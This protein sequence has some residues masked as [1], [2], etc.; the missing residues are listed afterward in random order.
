MTERV[1][2][3]DALQGWLSTDDVKQK[4]ASTLRGYERVVRKMGSL[5]KAG[6]LPVYANDLSCSDLDLVIDTL[7]AGSSNGRQRKLKPRSEA[8]L[9]TDRT[10]LRKICGYFQRQ[11][12]T[13]DDRSRYLTFARATRTKLYED[14][15]LDGPEQAQELLEAAGRRHPRDRMVVALGLFCGLRE[16]EILDLKLRDVDLS[17]RT[18]DFFREKQDARHFVDLNDAALRELR[19]YLMWYA[20]KYGPVHDNMHL[21][22]ARAVAQIKVPPESISPRWPLIPTKRAYTFRRDIRILLASIGK[23]VAEGQGIHVLR[24][25]FA[26]AML[27]AGADIRHVQEALGHK[28]VATTERYVNRSFERERLR[29]AY[30][31]PGFRLWGEAPPTHTG[32]NVVDLRTYRSQAG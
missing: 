23:P 16:S 19:T 3:V 18:L 24:R 7:R 17:R 20:D 30:R 32:E 10:I 25:T 2:L 6:E 15:F 28:N 8:S 13:V 27:D 14:L 4:S 9:N 11:G 5:Q 29:A 21:C 26:N 31:Q 12:Y 22:P 1:K